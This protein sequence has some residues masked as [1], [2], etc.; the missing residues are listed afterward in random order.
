[1]LKT[2]LIL[3]HSDSTYSKNPDPKLEIKIYFNPY[4]EQAQA[5]AELRLGGT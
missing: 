1:M 3:D 2:V 4:K 5:L